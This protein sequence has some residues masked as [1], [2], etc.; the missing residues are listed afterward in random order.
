MEGAAVPA[1]EV[2]SGAEPC[3]PPQPLMDLPAGHPSLLFFTT[4]CAETE[5]KWPQPPDELK[6]ELIQNGFN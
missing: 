3:P 1:E 6:L 2:A 4:A 5:P